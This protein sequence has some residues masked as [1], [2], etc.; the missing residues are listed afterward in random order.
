ML[1]VLNFN[2]N[3]GLSELS[4]PDNNNSDNQLMILFLI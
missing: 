2:G 1:N 4:P 3:K